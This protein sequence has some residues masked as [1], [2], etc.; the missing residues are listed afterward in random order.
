M[1]DE[2]DELCTICGKGDPV[3]SDN[4]LSSDDG[5]D[6]DTTNRVSVDSM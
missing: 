1:N 5:H 4:G 6:V 3:E 2:V